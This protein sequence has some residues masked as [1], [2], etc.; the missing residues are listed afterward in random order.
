VIDRKPKSAS[1]TQQWR[2]E[3]SI[4]E[5]GKESKLKSHDNLPPIRPYLS[6]S[7]SGL[8]FQDNGRD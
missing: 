1:Q 7:I 6:G 3:M 2:E 8:E 5:K 4:V